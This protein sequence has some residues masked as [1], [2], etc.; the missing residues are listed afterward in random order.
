MIQLHKKGIAAVIACLALLLVSGRATAADVVTMADVSVRPGASQQVSVVLSNETA[1]T[2]FQL[3]ITLSEGLSLAKENGKYAIALTARANGHTV[4]VNEL[5]DN[6]IRVA[7]YSMTNNNFQGNDGAV[8]TFKIEAAN[9]FAGNGTIALD[10]IRFTTSAIKEVHF[11]STSATVK[12]MPDI[13]GD[14]NGDGRLDIGD[15]IAL[16]NFL[17]GR[18]AGVLTAKI[19]VNGDGKVNL[20]D[21]KAL[22]AMIAI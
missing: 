21:I 2:A 16:S 22:I 20:A 13:K 10:N 14:V 5:S 12:L 8:L 18:T 6:C 7:A 17:A 19:D 15:I 11:D 3:D 4:S 1:F 9:D